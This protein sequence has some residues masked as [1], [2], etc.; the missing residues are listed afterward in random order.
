M[1]NT[2][3]KPVI[4]ARREIASVLRRYQLAWEEVAPDRDDLIWEKIKPLAKKVRKELFQKSYP[5]FS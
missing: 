5:K 1:L 2:V 4:R 3:E